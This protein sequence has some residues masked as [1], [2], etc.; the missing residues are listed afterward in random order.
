MTSIS[1]QSEIHRVAA[2]PVRVVRVGHRRRPG[3]RERLLRLRGG[4]QRRR[5]LLRQL[6]GPHL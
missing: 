6:E 4:R 1:F 2:E 5:L 3:V